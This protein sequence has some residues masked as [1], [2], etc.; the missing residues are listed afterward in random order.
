M[1]VF[2]DV[3]ITHTASSNVTDRRGH[4]G[5]VCFIGRNNIRSWDVEPFY[6]SGCFRNSGYRLYLSP[7]YRLHQE[8]VEKITG[9]TILTLLVLYFKYRFRIILFGRIE[10]IS[11]TGH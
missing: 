8:L 9:K 10:H 2:F 11:V 6:I 4:T 3:R 1:G 5:I 7:C